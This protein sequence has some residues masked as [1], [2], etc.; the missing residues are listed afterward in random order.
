MGLGDGALDDETSLFALCT[1]LKAW[2][3]FLEQQPKKLGFHN[4][5][6]PAAASRSALAAA[7]PRCCLRYETSFWLLKVG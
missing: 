3:A 6:M 2:K 4:F 1:L 5:H 7:G